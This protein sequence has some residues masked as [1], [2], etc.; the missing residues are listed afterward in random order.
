MRANAAALCQM[1]SL[2]MI[3]HLHAE[4]TILIKGAH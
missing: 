4:N 1:D 2:T 3:L